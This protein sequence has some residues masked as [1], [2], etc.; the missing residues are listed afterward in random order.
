MKRCAC[1]LGT[2][3]IL[4]LAAMAP[5]ARAACGAGAGGLYSGYSPITS[6]PDWPRGASYCGGCGPAFDS[7]NLT[8]VFWHLGFGDQFTDG[9]GDDSGSWHVSNWMQKAFVDNPP[10][11]YRGVF[12]GGGWGGDLAVDNCILISDP[13]GCSCIALGDDYG[14]VQIGRFAVMGSQINPSLAQFDYRNPRGCSASSNCDNLELVPIPTPD[15]LA[16]RAF[17]NGTWDLDV[18]VD[19]PAGGV[20]QGFGD[21][22]CNPTAYRIRAVSNDDG[23]PTSV[24]P[25]TRAK[26][27]WALL[28]LGNG[29]GVPAGAQPEAGTPLGASIV[30]HVACRPDELRDVYLVTELFFE[31]GPLADFQLDTVSADSPRVDCRSTLAQPDD[32][33]PRRRIRGSTPRPVRRGGRGR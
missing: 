8:G 22:D 19:P 15:L 18:R 3:M 30:V 21:C 25:G 26:T 24:D 31:N 16:S 14:N 5:D 33:E 2:W 9:V 28:P 13:N 20:Y 7:G 32:I 4:V 12:T 17:P 6:N 23:V 27:A 10:Y 29:T 11:Y 1:S